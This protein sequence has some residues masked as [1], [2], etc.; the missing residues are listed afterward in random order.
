VWWRTQPE[1]QC[2]SLQLGWVSEMADSQHADY[3]VTFVETGGLFLCAQL[4]DTARTK[5]AA[6]HLGC[7]NHLA[8]LFKCCIAGDVLG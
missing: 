2:C 5:C 6:C 1:R 3:D 4:V 7:Q 8:S